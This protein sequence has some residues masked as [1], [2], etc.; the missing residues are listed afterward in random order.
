MNNNRNI[1]LGVD[2]GLHTTGYCVLDI[3]TG[4]AKLLQ[5][6]TVHSSKKTLQGRIKDIFDGIVEVIEIFHPTVLALEQI[7]SHYQRPMTGVWMGHAR[8]VICLA[9]EQGKIPVVSYAPTK[10]KKT[11][12]GSGRAQKDQIQRAVM[13]EL[14]LSQIPDPPYVADAIAIAFCHFTEARQAAKF[15]NQFVLEAEKLKRS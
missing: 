7:Y 8:G 14:K 1:I 13:F 4:Q 2:P 9:A 5:A 12:T 6:G 11:L 10:I 3:T 15:G